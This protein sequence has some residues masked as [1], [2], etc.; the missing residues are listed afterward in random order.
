MTSTDR[1]RAGGSP[2]T[3]EELLADITA[4]RSGM[5]R[6]DSPNRAASMFL[7]RHASSVVKELWIGDSQAA[8]GSSDPEQTS[9]PA[10]YE[11]EMARIYNTMPRS[12]G[13]VPVDQ[14]G[15]SSWDTITAGQLE[16]RGP[17]GENKRITSGQSATVTRSGTGV[18][19]FYTE[20]QTGGAVADV[21]INGTS[22]GT[23]DSRNA[24]LSASYDSGVSAYFSHPDDVYGP[25]EVVVAH[26]GTGTTFELEGGYFHADNAVTGHMVMRGD[27]SGRSFDRINDATT[28]AGLIQFIANW[29][30]HIITISLGLN[31]ANVLGLNH[32]ADVAAADM[33][34]FLASVRAEYSTWT[35][36]IRY[37]FQTD[38]GFVPATWPTDYR[39]AFRQ[40]C[41]DDDVLF[42]DEHDAV[43][44][45]R[46]ADPFDWSDDAFPLHPN[47]YGHYARA[48]LVTAL[49]AKT[50][51]TRV[52]PLDIENSTPQRVNAA[53]GVLE[54]QGDS[55]V[56]LVLARQAGT[57]AVNNNQLGY[58]G[59]KGAVDTG[60]ST[61]F[62]AA[63]RGRAVGTWTPSSSPANIEF[64]TSASAG[65]GALV[66][67]GGFSSAQ[68]FWIGTTTAAATL[69]IDSS[70][71][72]VSAAQGGFATGLAVGRSAPL[73]TQRLEIHRYGS[74]ANQLA[75]YS[76]LGTSGS[77]TA[78]GLLTT[79]GSLRMFG[80]EGTTPGFGVGGCEISAVAA[81]TWTSTAQGA[82]LTFATTPNNSTTAIEIMRISSDAAAPSVRIQNALVV[83]AL[84]GPAAGT[85]LD[86]NTGVFATRRSTMTLAN[87]ANANVTLPTTSLVFISGPS[88]A[89]SI[90]GIASPTNGM[91]LRLINLTG[92]AMTITHE[93]TSTAANRITCLTGADLVTTGNGAVD[94]DYDS[95]TT[96]WIASN[97]QA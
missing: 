80:Y 87:G 18:R 55:G 71:N 48:Q 91:R 46:T 93:A 22:V 6:F 9:M 56:A 39:E 3:A 95:T 7:A 24:G 97:F 81:Q 37:V 78:V 82:Y 42:I 13:F 76:A 51:N 40:V 84:T 33:A 54:T 23:I 90:S 15:G 79:L 50:N 69:T 66:V 11:T 29:Q 38:N 4:E 92:Q 12:C 64:M 86:V 27:R 65:A 77:P 41:I 2:L 43:G 60:G 1:L 49:T 74:T 62:G 53:F 70:G 73:A 58:I 20:Q 44:E 16:E 96:R 63:V 61:Q 59:F 36:A 68:G 75:F 47:D 5:R 83:G 85:G 94:L 57:A 17:N 67:A 10:V 28:G 21:T 25:M 30:P 32:S 19:I 45:V 8:T 31:D 88:G 72:L 35:P 26:S 34:T 89:F 52:A 14:T